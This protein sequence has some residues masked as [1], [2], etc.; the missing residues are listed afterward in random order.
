MSHVVTLEASR[1]LV[2]D[3]ESIIHHPAELHSVVAEAKTSLSET[4]HLPNDMIWDY[5]IWRRD[6]DPSRFDHYHPEFLG[7]FMQ[8]QR[9]L[10]QEQSTN[11][12]ADDPIP[13]SSIPMPTVS[14]PTISISTSGGNNGAP[15]SGSHGGQSGVSTGLDPYAG[16]VPEPPSI[17]L[18]AVA[19]VVAR[20]LF[21]FK[22][23]GALACALAPQP[24]SQ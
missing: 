16:S 21:R 24:M 3:I 4:G 7:V 14:I 13:V 8:E 10:E 5:L 6:L 22:R 18:L 1:N 11:D 20:I 2:S 15:T 17:V 19:L 12:P 23:R 9:L